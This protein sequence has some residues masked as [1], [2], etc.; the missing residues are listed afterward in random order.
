MNKEIEN[1]IIV[2]N[3]FDAHCGLKSNFKDFFQQI[4]SSLK[5]IENFWNEPIHYESELPVNKPRSTI[6]AQLIGG[7]ESN[8]LLAEMD[9]QKLE[10]QTRVPLFL[11]SRTEIESLMGNKI[12]TRPEGGFWAAYFNLKNEIP[13][14][15]Y[16][17]EK[18]LRDFFE[19]SVSDIGIQDSSTL[20]HDYKSTTMTQFEGIYESI[21]AL[22][23]ILNGDIDSE[24]AQKKLTYLSEMDETTQKIV[25]L[26]INVF[27]F[28]PEQDK[29]SDFLLIHLNIIENVFAKYLLKEV[30]GN[31][32]Y[33]NKAQLV[34][35]KLSGN[36]PYNLLDF[37]YTEPK[38]Q[39][40]EVSRNIHSTLE[41]NPIFGIDSAEVNANANYYQFTKT[42]RIMRLER[43]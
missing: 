17:V 14:Y 3:G 29:L 30:K 19:K 35:S 42:Y 22:E 36:T 32:D 15:W 2:G 31:T 43:V 23:V 25:Y 39:T 12:I 37:N 38:S 27:S 16:D 7:N 24:E 11:K 5:D 6:V 41:N 40:L 18:I 34:L 33:E 20:K 28:D 21:A 10:S 13:N 1:L 8:S 4:S 26:L 9:I